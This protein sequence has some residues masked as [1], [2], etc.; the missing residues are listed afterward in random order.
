MPLP[1]GVVNAF[2]V[3]TEEW[4]HI[5]GVEALTPDRWPALSSRIELTTV[6]R[7]AMQRR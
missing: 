2:T 1:G 5:C 3:D 7:L 6:Q 4:F